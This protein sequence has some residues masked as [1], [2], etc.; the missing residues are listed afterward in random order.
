MENKKKC[1]GCGAEYSGE[2]MF[3]KECG[4]AL[5]TVEAEAEQPAQV[6]NDENLNNEEVS[7]EQKV[8]QAVAEPVAEPVAQPVVAESPVAPSEE[9]IN[10]DD[11]INGV[12]TAVLSDYVGEKSTKFIPKFK[13]YS[14]GAKAGWNWPVFLFGLLLGIPF[15]WFFYRKMYK[16]GVLFLAISIAFSVG[17]TLTAVSVVEALGDASEKHIEAFADEVDDIEDRYKLSVRPGKETQKALDEQKEYEIE[18]AAENTVKEFTKDLLK[19]DEFMKMTIISYLI[20]LVNFAYVV[21]VSMF[22]NSLY[23]RSAVGSVVKLGRTGT[24]SQEKV[25]ASGGVNSASGALAGVFGS[26]ALFAIAF[27][28]VMFKIIDIIMNVIEKLPE[29]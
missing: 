14:R 21:I 1:L 29:F 12:P 20:S 5:Q 22:A 3:C 9:A 16:L 10:G 24:L 13:K 23:Y 7:N 19:N 17:S 18:K 15:V 11:F 2:Y 4:S 26:I 25:K 27:V 6:I 8:E 28:P